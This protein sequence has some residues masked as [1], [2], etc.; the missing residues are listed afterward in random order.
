MK[1]SSMS[2]KRRV[3]NVIFKAASICVLLLLVLWARVFYGAME[4]YN[5]GEALL[6]ENQT[7]RA[8][9]YFDRSLHW[10]APLNPYVERAAKRLWD[11]GEKAEK[12]NIR[13]EKA[14]GG[15][16]GKPGSVRRGLTRRKAS[17]GRRR[18]S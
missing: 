2:G 4:D 14:A 18:F 9:T 5:K 8:I 10:Y 15:Q 6:E 3:S 17:A 16:K 13:K 11:I 1:S 12:E 7:I